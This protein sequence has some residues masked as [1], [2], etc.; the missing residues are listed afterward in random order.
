MHDIYT[1]NQN[2][3]SNLGTGTTHKTARSFVTYYITFMQPLNSLQF[4]AFINRNCVMINLTIKK[5]F[6]VY[7]TIYFIH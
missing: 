1:S 6:S 3:I 5:A 7:K 2:I 4:I